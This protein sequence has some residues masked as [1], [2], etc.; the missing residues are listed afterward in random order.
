MNYE[1]YLS[2]VERIVSENFRPN[3]PSGGM[4]AARAGF[5]VRQVLGT[6][7]EQV[8]LSKFREALDELAR[9]NRIRVG[10]N[11]KDALA[12]WILD[13]AAM[14]SGDTGGTGSAGESPAPAFLPRLRNS[15]WLAFVSESPAGKRYLHRQTGHIVVG[16][17]APP[18]S[19]GWIEIPAVTPETEKAAAERFVRENNLEKDPRLQ[20]ALQSGTWYKDFPESLKQIDERLRRQWNR[21][22]SQRVHAI[23]E[24][25]RQSNNISSNLI[26]EPVTEKQRSNQ[27]QQESSRTDSAGELHAMLLQAVGRM[28]VDELMELRIPARYLIAATRPDLLNG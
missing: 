20:A 19:E 16:R 24:P 4:T 23:V 26:Y 25:W 22:R 27:W 5:L 14:E 10:P 1:D 13:E 3:D 6:T 11:S 8:G 17:D 2:E 9:R 18:S 28:S 15:L 21:S 7:P 12:I